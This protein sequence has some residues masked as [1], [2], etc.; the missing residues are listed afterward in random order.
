MINRLPMALGAELRCEDWKPGGDGSQKA[1]GEV[2]SGQVN[3]LMV[4]VCLFVDNVER[5]SC[6]AAWD[7][8]DSVASGRR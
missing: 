6:L 2:E 1:R 3:L 5:R 7:T 8:K 4:T